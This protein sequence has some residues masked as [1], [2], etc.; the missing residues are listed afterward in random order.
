MG[1]DKPIWE[2]VF[3][4]LYK[5]ARQGMTVWQSHRRPE[6]AATSAEPMHAARQARSREA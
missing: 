1:A 4:G 3:G 6:S 2:T 5:R